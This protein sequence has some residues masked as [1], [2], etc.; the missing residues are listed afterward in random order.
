MKVPGTS[1]D[2]IVNGSTSHDDIV[3]KLKQI[4]FQL[5]EVQKLL[6]HGKDYEKVMH[7]FS[8]ARKTLHSVSIPLILHLL[9]REMKARRSANG[10]ESV[11]ARE[12]IRSLE[13]L[14]VYHG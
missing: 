2:R 6:E 3:K 10:P 12:A 9:A 13:S 4:E 14:L 1:A 5:R 8:V 7:R 11:D